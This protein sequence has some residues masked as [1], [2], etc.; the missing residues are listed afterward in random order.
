MIQHRRFLIVGKGDV[1]EF[2]GNW[3]SSRRKRRR[4]VRFRLI[5]RVQIRP[6][7][8][9]RRQ[10]LKHLTDTVGY[11]G[12]QSGKRSHGAACQDKI[13]RRDPSAAGHPQKV[14]IRHT[15]PE[16]QCR[17]LY[18]RRLIEMI[19][20][21]LAETE[22]RVP[23]MVKISPDPPGHLIEP[24]ILSQI[25]VRGLRPEIPPSVLDSAPFQNPV[26]FMLLGPAQ[27]QKMHHRQSDQQKQQ[28]WIQLRKDG[29]VQEE[30]ENG[31]KRLYRA[32]GHQCGSRPLSPVDAHFPC[33][34]IP[35]LP[36]GALYMFIITFQGLRKQAVSIMA[37]QTV[38]QHRLR[39]LR[40]LGDCHGSGDPSQKKNRPLRIRL[41]RHKIHAEFRKIHSQIRSDNG[42]DSLHDHKYQQLRITAAD[43]FQ[44][45]DQRIPE[46]IRILLS[47]A[48]SLLCGF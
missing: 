12:H 27:R 48:V 26:H 21:I 4:R 6:H 35:F 47:F 30:A 31:G 37:A 24:E 9:Q 38:M 41:L 32:L 17:R 45:K 11:L 2:H 15:V 14:Q 10:R 25:D 16:K 29:A 20:N 1:P 19:L 46:S 39:P 28:P 42:T 23:V 33:L 8:F 5:R 34:L 36:L 43:S 40:H 13:S 18:Q 22:M 44:Q 7:P 3:R